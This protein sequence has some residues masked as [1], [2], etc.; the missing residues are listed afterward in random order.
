[1]CSLQV[2]LLQFGEV[3]R[4]R[5]GSRCIAPGAVGALAYLQAIGNAEPFLWLAMA[6]L[7]PAQQVEK[8][9]LHP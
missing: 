4:F 1:M 8:P 3:G 7:P 5:F 6:R 9:T 2:F